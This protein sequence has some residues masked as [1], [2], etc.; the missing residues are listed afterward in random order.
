M[1]A[2]ERLAFKDAYDLAMRGVRSL[3][4]ATELDEVERTRIELSLTFARLVPWS[5]WRGYGHPT[6]EALAARA[7]ALADQLGEPQAIARALGMM[8]FVKNVRA[9]CT[10]ARDAARR[11]AVLAPALGDPALLINAHL[12]AQIACH[13]LG[14]FADADAHAGEVMRL[15]RDLR[16]PDRFVNVFDPLVASLAESSRNAWITGRLTTA[17]ALAE[18]AVILGAE[19]RNPESLA[20]AWLFRAFLDGY[21][22]DWPACAHAAETG[23]AI[24]RDAGTVQTLAWNQCVRGWGNAHMGD[25][26]SGRQDLAE[27]I[28]LSQSIMGKIA[29]PQF[30]L[31]MAEV[32]LL[33]GARDD[34]RTWVSEALA[35]SEEQDDSYFAAEMHRMAAICEVPGPRRL[36]PVEHIQRALDVARQQGASFFELR[37]AMTGA[38]I[39]GDMEPLHRALAGIVEPEAWAD[40]TVAAKRCSRQ[41]GNP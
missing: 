7:S 17:R 35:A 13:H 15:G 22:G 12:I 5:S 14:H 19:V 32:L 9:E 37:A 34:A 36:S 24:A 23:L 1:H 29:L 8:C 18:Q 33:A 41:V 25:V 16:P 6:T 10:A 28:A 39:T 11:L 2:T 27:G 21:R 38:T 30:R 26:E 20:F 3:A 40:V 31:M 4:Q